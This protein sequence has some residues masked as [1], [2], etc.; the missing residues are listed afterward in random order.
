MG[1]QTRKPRS[2]KPT[3]RVPMGGKDWKPKFLAKLAELGV[4]LPACVGAGVSKFAAYTA[5]AKDPQ[6]AQDWAD[7]IE[8]H[9]Q[10]LEAELFRRAT[11][12]N[13][14]TALIFALKGKR[15]EVY[16]ESRSEIHIHAE[17][18][19]APGPVASAAITAGLSA[20]KLKMDEMGGS[21]DGPG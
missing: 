4:V 1:D 8:A 15:P 3:P 21:T 2:K 20:A 5:K 16:R 19:A 13:D 7:A 18:K 12:G 9:I 17:P 14:T 6:F 11:K 10:S